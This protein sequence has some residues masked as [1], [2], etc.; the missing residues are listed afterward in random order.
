[1]ALLFLSTETKRT[2]T[3]GLTFPMEVQVL[4]DGLG[5]AV[6][7]TCHREIPTMAAYALC[8][9]ADGHRHQ[10]G[11]IEGLGR[12]LPRLRIGALSGAA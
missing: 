10:Q 12:L 5:G 9:S 8:C 4:R 6:R 2:L 1:M 11:R 7:L 3:L